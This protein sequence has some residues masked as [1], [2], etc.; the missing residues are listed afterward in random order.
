M[1]RDQAFGHTRRDVLAAGGA[2]AA[3]AVFAGK[4]KAEVASAAGGKQRGR[5]LICDESSCRHG[6]GLPGVMISN[7]RKV[8]VTGTR[9]E[10]ALEPG[11]DGTLFVIKPSGWTYLETSGVPRLSP[12]M[13]TGEG[14]SASLDFHLRPQTE[15]E[16]FEVALLADT[17]AANALELGYV[18]SELSRCQ[19]SRGYAFAINHG[20]VMG[21]DLSLLRPYKDIVRSTGIIWHHCPGNHDMDLASASNARAFDTWK[22]DIG[23]D[24]Y[25]FQ[26]A[27]CTFILLNNVEYLGAGSS[28]VGG[29]LYTGRI[30][31]TQLD[32]VRN[33][34]AHVP[35]DHLV[36]VSMHIPLRSFENPSAPGD[37]TADCAELMTLLAE[38]PHTVS[39]SGHSH[40]TEHHYLG[41][42]AGFN[43]ANTHHHHVLTAFCGSWWGGPLNAQGIPIADSRDGSPRG[44]HVLRVQGHTYTTRF[45]ALGDPDGAVARTYAN[46]AT[47]EDPACVHHGLTVDVFDGGPNTRISCVMPGSQH[48]FELQRTTM[49]DPHIIDSYARHRGLLK[50][51]VSPAPSS[52]IWTGALPEEISGD[53]ILQITDEYGRQ[54]IL[55]IRV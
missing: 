35:K 8:V 37:N 1:P 3:A 23:P 26:Y 25:A 41:P 46:H 12:A 18:R 21:D 44:F 49:P 15:P 53:C 16:T 17:Q 14:T 2:L 9:G 48:A 40:T 47:I 54:R 10:W 7:G 20:D 27:R 19:M 55:P 50:P 33:V 28:P 52:H 24:H 39:F 38:F 6:A 11:P 34:L 45:V 51:W 32:F 4:A 29:R 22:R 13:S 31:R 36:V 42:E 30:G 5:V 43:R